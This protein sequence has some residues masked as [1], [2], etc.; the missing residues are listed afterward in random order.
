MKTSLARQAHWCN[1][2]TNVKGVANHFMVGF[3]FHPVR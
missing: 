1:N 2:G 3:K